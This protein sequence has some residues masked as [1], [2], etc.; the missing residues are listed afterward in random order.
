MEENNPYKK[1][2]KHHLSG[3]W[4]GYCPESWLKGKTVRMRLN[5]WDF[6]ESEETGLQIAVLGG[7]QAVILNFRGSRDFRKTPAYGDEV[8]MGQLL[9]PQNLEEAPFNEPLEVFKDSAEIEAYISAIKS[10]SSDSITDSNEHSQLNEFWDDLNGGYD[11]PTLEER[12]DSHVHT[13]TNYLCLVVGNHPY[14]IVECEIYYYDKD[15]HPDPYVHKRK[16]Q[17]TA[18]KWY[19]NDMGLDITFG[20]QTAI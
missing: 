2:E 20:R 9:S 6:Y 3:T 16:Q 11:F 8:E 19:F 18:G 1:I 13:L 12:F 14:R 4:N 15:K 17:L 5:S 7:V 10:A